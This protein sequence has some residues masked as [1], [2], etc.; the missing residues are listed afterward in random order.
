MARCHFE[1]DFC[2]GRGDSGARRREVFEMKSEWTWPHVV[3]VGIAASACTLL[4]LRGVISARELGEILGAFGAGSLF[5]Q[6]L[7]RP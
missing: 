7:R 1:I 6:A 2:D 5:P 3:L 4:M